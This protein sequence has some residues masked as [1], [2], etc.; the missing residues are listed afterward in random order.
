MPEARDET[1]LIPIRKAAKLSAIPESELRELA[2]KG[3]IRGWQMPRR[4]GGQ[5][6]VALPDVAAA[7]AA[8]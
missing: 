2:R 3:L 1:R 7:A 5:Q 4:V 8:R 6:L